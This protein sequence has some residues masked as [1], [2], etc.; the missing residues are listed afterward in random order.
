MLNAFGIQQ[1]PPFYKNNISLKGTGK[2]NK[3][4]SGKQGGNHTEWRN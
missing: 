3:A 1:S 2:A 4:L